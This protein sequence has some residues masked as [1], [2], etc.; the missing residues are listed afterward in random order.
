MCRIPSP[1]LTQ[2]MGFLPLLHDLGEVLRGHA[3]AGIQ[4]SWQVSQAGDQLVQGGAWRWAPAGSDGTA[5]GPDPTLLSL[6]GPPHPWGSPG[7][8][9]CETR[10][11]NMLAASPEP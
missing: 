10:R 2:V 4:A 3:L 6:P 11:E 9:S 7:A 5:G 8:A 1:Q